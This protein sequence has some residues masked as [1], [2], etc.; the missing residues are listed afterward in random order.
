MDTHANTV[1]IGG[2]VVGC[3]VLYHLAKAGCEDCLLIERAELTVGSSWHAAGGMHMLNGDP[4]VAGLQKY[5]MEVM[6]EIEELSGQS[7]GVHITG[8]LLLAGTEERLDW[9]RMLVARGRFHGVQHRILSAG[10]A[11]ELFPIMDPS[12]FVGAMLDEH[13]GHV[14]PSGVTHAYAKAAQKLGA[15]VR[16]RDRVVETRQR[17]DGGWDVVTEQGTVH[18]ERVVNAGG[19]WAREV[20]RMAGLELPVLAMEHHYILTDDMPEVIEAQEKSG[21]QLIHAT[22]FSGELYMRQERMGMLMGTYEKAC[23]PWSMRE[24]PWDFGPELLQPDM[25]RIAPS[26][27]VGFRHFPAFSRA[28]I[29]ETINGPFTFAPDGNPLVGPVRGLPNYWVAVGVMAGFSQA[30][31][32]GLAL[33]SWMETGDPGADIWGMDVAR[34][35][36]WTTMAYTRAK[37]CENYSR[38]FQ[39]RFPN[40]ELPAGRPLLASP[41]YHRHRAMGAVM[42][43]SAGLE[44][45][46]WYAPEGV[47]DVLSFRRSTDFPHVAAECRAVREAVGVAEITGFAKYEVTGDG[48]R[49]W[50]D[51]VLAGRLPRQGRMSLTPMLNE[52]GRLIGDFTT[53]QLG[54]GHYFMVGSGAAETY[55]M[56]WFEAQDPQGAGAAVDTL[57][58][59]MGGLAIAG[60]RS[61]DL[62]AR[63]VDEDVSTAAFPFMAIRMMD[64]AMV[65]CLVGRVSYTGDLGYEI[66]CPEPNLAGLYE[67]VLEAGAGLGLRPFGSRALNG[68]RLEKGF[69]SWATEYRPLYG[70]VEAGLDRFVAYD[71]NAPF[72]GRD[73]A[74]EEREQGGETRLRVFLVDTPDIDVLGDEPIWRGG[75]M[76]GRVT[77]GGYAH[78]S[79]RSVALGYV[80]REIA[81]EAEGWSVEILDTRHP[82]TL[83]SEPL[84]DPEGTRMRA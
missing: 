76:C 6:A 78:A 43:E 45:P 32:V 64:V 69:G 77:S 12:F 39:I 1:V 37:V 49:E 35:G 29:R 84:F 44:V 40:E 24:T 17:A 82:A 79:G 71:K 53:A 33:A 46:L 55:H 13:T 38:R 56:R 16:L 27:E 65:T 11:H 59:A 75:A 74:L 8:G 58:L 60:P 50:L 83:Q 7:C 22:D 4:N 51:R 48:A 41:L 25:E 31:G 3:S 30:G 23:V 18:A 57:G 15:K 62:L 9:L 34:Y 10:E 36:D 47:S 2:G 68:L 80:P 81:D 70:P 5:T 42:G 26:L 19:L 14:D 72:I 67:R 61:R 21:H 20:G 54:E 73:A 28:G 66:W 52:R 63:L